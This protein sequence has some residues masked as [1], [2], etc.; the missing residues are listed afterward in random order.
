MVSTD[1][2]TDLYTGPDLENLSRDG[3][4]CT[5][6]DG[7]T[8][9]EEDTGT[10]H[11]YPEDADN[12]SG[13]SSNKLSHWT[14][15]DDDLLNA[16][17]QADALDVTGQPWVTGDPEIIQMGDWYYLFTDNTT[18]HPNYNIA[19]AVGK[20]LD[21]FT[22]I[23]ANITPERLGGDL[24]IV[25]RN[26]YFEAL[27]E[28]DNGNANIGHWR[29]WPHQL[30]QLQTHGQVRAPSPG[31]S[32]HDAETDHTRLEVSNPS[33]D[34]LFLD[35]HRHPNGGAFYGLRLLNE[36]DNEIGRFVSTNNSEAGM[37]AQSGNRAFLGVAGSG[38]KELIAE[39]GAVSTHMSSSPPSNPQTNAVYMDDGTNTGDGAPGLR[40]T[41][42]G[43]STWSDV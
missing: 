39:G 13:V 34:D 29:L 35:V 42:D 26:G 43:G 40:Y 6:P 28:Y 4:F 18:N 1:S 24:T 9:Y 33:G 3:Q 27:T 8:F 41:T 7:G 23:D 31:P 38:Q 32:F 36:N 25:P 5:E 15:S 37:E 2:A 10:L 11:Y 12:A 14:A 22:L 17:Q 19:L 16:T 30:G 21:S 20:T